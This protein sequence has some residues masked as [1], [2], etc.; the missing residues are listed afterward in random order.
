MNIIKWCFD[1]TLVCKFIRHN[2]VFR[3]NMNR[4]NFTL[5]LSANNL[6]QKMS[7]N[8][9]LTI[10]LTGTLPLNY[11][12]CLEISLRQRSRKIHSVSSKGLGVASKD[13]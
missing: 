10:P 6:A 9:A 12:E 4:A 8:R 3:E 7:V 11:Y 1:S 13:T 5:F 2:V